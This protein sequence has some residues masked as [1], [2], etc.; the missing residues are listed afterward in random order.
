MNLYSVAAGEVPHVGN[1]K[2]CIYLA[3]IIVG[4]AQRIMHQIHLRHRIGERQRVHHKAEIARLVGIHRPE[5]K[6]Y[7]IAAAPYRVKE[8]SVGI[9]VI[10]LDGTY[11]RRVAVYPAQTD[12]AYQSVGIRL[13][14]LS[15][16]PEQDALPGQLVVKR[17]SRVGKRDKRRVAVAAES[18]ARPC[19]AGAFHRNDVAEEGAVVIISVVRA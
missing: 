1:V 12:C 5:M 17:Q 2:R 10:A 15:V 18:E 7:V 8:H 3:H 6:V 9:P 16:I 14:R 11:D 13:S 19:V 4:S